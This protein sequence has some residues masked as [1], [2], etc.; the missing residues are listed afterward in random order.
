VQVPANVVM[1]KD[2]YNKIINVQLIPE[3]LMI[4]MKASLGLPTGV[5]S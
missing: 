2:A 1:V 3:Q 5:K 4:N